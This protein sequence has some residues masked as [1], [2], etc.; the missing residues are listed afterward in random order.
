MKDPVIQEEVDALKQ[1]VDVVNQQMKVLQDLNVEVRISYV[2][3]SISKDVDQG[4]EVWRIEEH[5][6]YL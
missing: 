1:A 3:K 6:S 2:E 5:N 4:I